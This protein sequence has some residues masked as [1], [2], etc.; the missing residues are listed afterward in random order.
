MLRPLI[1]CSFY[2]GLPHHILDTGIDAIHQICLNEVVKNHSN[3]LSLEN[4]IRIMHIRFESL[5]FFITN[6]FES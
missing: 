6:I 3:L 4:T 5:F 2:L 1:V